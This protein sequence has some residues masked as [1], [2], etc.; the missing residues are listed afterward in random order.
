MTEGNAT[1]GRQCKTDNGASATLQKKSD[2]LCALYSK[3]RY[4]YRIASKT[5]WHKISQSADYITHTTNEPS[6][7]IIGIRLFEADSNL[8]KLNTMTL[9]GSN[10]NKPG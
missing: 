1:R 5:A 3:V 10:M 2:D 6:G 9:K 7:L 4:N 8:K